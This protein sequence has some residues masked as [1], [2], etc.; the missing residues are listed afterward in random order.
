M[1]PELLELSAFGPF[2]GK[3]VID[4]SAFHGQIF[5]LTGETGSGK[6][7]IFDAISFALFGEASGGRERRS[8]KSFRSDYADPE[9]PTYVTLIFT[10]G[11]KRYTVTRSPEYERAKKRGLGTT[12]VPSI[13]SLITEGEERV[14]TRIDEVDARIVE[15]V[16]LDR[17]QGNS[18]D[19]GCRGRHSDRPLSHCPLGGR[20]PPK[21]PL[22]H[23]CQA[24]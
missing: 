20:N 14:I 22:S 15:I 18:Q 9:T 10:E 11:G 8:G 3:T 16:G 6:T 7:S 23:F 5:L 21:P 12:V 19:P 4:F 24:H 13:A 2:K 17:R 1:R